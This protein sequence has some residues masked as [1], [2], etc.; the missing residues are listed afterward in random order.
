M[1]RGGR[2]AISVSSL[3]PRAEEEEEEEEEEDPRTILLRGYYYYYYYCCCYYDNNWWDFRHSEP[4][5]SFS[6]FFC[7]RVV[8]SWKVRLIC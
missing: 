2:Q 3:R 5:V 1:T 6:F 8:P 4:L 7:R